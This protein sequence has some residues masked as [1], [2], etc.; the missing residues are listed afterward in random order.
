MDR[1]STPG[2]GRGAQGRRPGSTGRSGGG[3][4]A[5]GRDAVGGRDGASGRHGAGGRDGAGRA[6]AGK[7][8]GR[9]AGRA[10]GSQRDR[11][12]APVAG[13]RRAQPT[14]PRLPDDVRAG[15]LD[16]SMRAELRTLSEVNAE[17]VAR[18]LVQVGRLLD[19][20]PEAAY[21]N[22]MAAQRR[23]GRVAIVREITGI[24]AYRTERFAEALAELRTARR[25]SGSV[26]LLPLIA[27][28]ERGLGRPERALDLATSPDAA[29]LSTAER[30][31]LSIVLS[32]A[33]RDLGQLDAAVLA[34]Q[35]ADL[36]QERA[37]W[38]P[39]LA[40]AYADALDAAGRDG[41]A[42]QWLE[43]VAAADLTG[44]TDAAERLA[45]LDGIG[46]LVDLE[47]DPDEG[48]DDRQ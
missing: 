42:R 23:A 27:D 46:E 21:A 14:E 31:E 22:A 16:R 44:E 41:E 13:P 38:W 33:R 10:P 45:E 19:V 26:H 36:K 6:A 15:E 48:P 39:R 40:Y 4:P 35:T 29:R 12:D 8:R 9:G 30:V 34:L 2:G 1:N 18:Y 20:N 7:D 5:G 11:P 3:R 47:D 43:R 17:T 28:A 32:G 24:A 37:S 25:L